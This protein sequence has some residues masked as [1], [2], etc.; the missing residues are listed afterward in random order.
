V[1]LGGHWTVL[2][3]DDDLRREFADPQ[4]DDRAWPTVTV[5]GHWR[6]APALVEASG[7]VLH[8]RAFSHAGLSGDDRRAWLWLDGVFSQGDVWLDGAYVG[9]T[10][11]YFVPHA[12]EVTDLVSAPGDHVLAVEV[13]CPAVDEDEPKRSLTGAYQSGD[14]LAPGANPGGLWRPVRLVETGPVTIRHGRAVCQDATEERAVLSLR[15]VLDTA[16]ARPARIHTVVAGIHH[17]LDQPLAAGENRVE[18]TVTVPQPVLWW[19][20]SLGGQPLHDVRVDVYLADDD[21]T[22]PSDSRH[23]RTGFRSVDLRNWICRVNGERLFLKGANLPP[24]RADPA[25]SSP[26]ELRRL[27]RLAR[28]AGLDFLRVHTHVAPPA[29]Y[30]AADEL[31]MLLWQDFPLQGRYARTVRREAV[32]QAREL[33]DLLGHH[34]SVSIWCAHDEPFDTPPGRERRRPLVRG[35]LPQ[36]VPSWNRTILDRSVKRVLAKSDRSRPV[37]AHSGVLPH[38]PQLDGTDAHLWFGWY[39]GDVRDLAAFAS[40]VPRQVRFV[41]AFGAQSL[42]EPDPA[43]GG[44]QPDWDALAAAGIEVE[45]LQRTVEGDDLASWARASRAHQAHVVRRT[46]ETLRRLKYRPTGGFSVHRLIDPKGRIGFGLLDEHGCPKPAWDALRAACRPLTVIA[47]ALPVRLDPGDKLDL[48]VHIVSD[49]RADRAGCVVVAM[50]DSPVGSQT[51]R[52]HGDAP[53]D[54]CAL[55]GR[56]RFTAPEMP[57]PV[58]LTLELRDAST[59]ELL[60]TN[61]DAS[62]IL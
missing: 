25:S 21:R 24:L 45:V 55:V 22:E 20:H 62:R 3:A 56:I 26:S 2:P 13:G 35:V 29:L 1:E 5:P 50:L 51:W 59:D 47:D 37:I 33:V 38:F 36:Q 7:P 43:T 17:D 58:S 6:D 32:R 19:P 31:G 49:Q 23:W 48:A 42:P 30:E 44:A 9:D 41:S 11:G 8:R 16:V 28:D 53:A 61:G 52:W 40:R 10:E 60:A 4:F 12:F 54:A 14:H 15:L 46:V 27:V 34:P 39:G 18:W 57:G